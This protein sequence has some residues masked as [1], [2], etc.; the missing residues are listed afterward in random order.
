MS[1]RRPNAVADMLASRLMARAVPLYRRAVRDWIDGDPLSPA[2]EELR[3]L[4]SRHLL[5]SMLLGAASQSRRLIASGLIPKPSDDPIVLVP[6]EFSAEAAIESAATA[7]ILD[8]LNSFVGEIPDL[9]RRAPELIRAA[10]ERA[11]SFT[12]AGRDRMPKLIERLIGLGSEGSVLPE[13]LPDPAAMI[14]RLLDDRKASDAIAGVLDTEVRTSMMGGFNSAGRREITLHADIMPVMVLDEIRDRRTRGNPS[15]MYPDS[16][17]HYQMDGFTAATDDPVWDRITPPN[18]YNCRGSVRGVTLAESREK[19]WI[20]EDGSVDREKLR[21]R[22]A[23]QW[24][25]I[26]RGEYPDPG[27]GGN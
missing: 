8:M 20:R 13:E 23:R 3:E 14:R 24:S 19:G 12:I 26:E 16:T 7:S 18:G 10:S 5:A 21:R 11:G 9:N 6:V 2:W 25:I 1:K 15:G 4:W 17:P 27:F 22:H